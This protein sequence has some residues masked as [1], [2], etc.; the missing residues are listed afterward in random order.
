MTGVGLELSFSTAPGGGVEKGGD[1]VT[2][3]PL[4]ESLPSAVL[5]LGPPKI[6]AEPGAFFDS[7]T[8]AMLGRP[9]TVVAATLAGTPNKL[10]HMASLVSMREFVRVSVNDFIGLANAT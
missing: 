4:P 9:M 7:S 8:S 3:P 10:V 6:R 5:R 1:A 2:R